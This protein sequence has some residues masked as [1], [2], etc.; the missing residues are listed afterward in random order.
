MLKKGF[1]RMGLILLIFGG[2][3]M[4]LVAVYRISDRLSGRVG[5]L[6]GIAALVILSVLYIY[7]FFKTS[8]SR[9]I[10]KSSWYGIISG[11]FLWGVLGELLE[12][13]NIL[14]IAE[15]NYFPLILLF[16]FLTLF[17]AV[18]KYIPT[19]IIFSLG[20]FTGIWLCHA[21]MIFQFEHLSRT[22]FST[23]IAA[24]IF[25][26]LTLFFGYR[27]VKAKTDVGNLAYSLI[28]VLSAWTV[29]E[30]IWGWRLI[31]GPWSI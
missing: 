12:H 5:F 26:L 10:V 13:L 25:L 19:G 18:K 20:H 27:M 17:F 22:H 9:D 31:P 6:L 28:T 21:I 11:L 30:Y 29:L 3:Y 23:Y 1:K 15:W 7:F 24:T 14:V 2:L 8:N 4:S 16:V